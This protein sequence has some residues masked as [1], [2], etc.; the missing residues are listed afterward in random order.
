MMW[1][2]QIQS[3]MTKRPAGNPRNMIFADEQ[4]AKRVASVQ[5]HTAAL[6]AKAA[7]RAELENAIIDFVR[8]RR[9]VTRADLIA[10]L[11]LSVSWVATVAAGLVDGGR[12]KSSIINRKM[13]WELP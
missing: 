8:K 1:A 10:H 3:L 2:T 12:L 7:R 5:A 11:N 4:V 6:A 9:A 13:Y